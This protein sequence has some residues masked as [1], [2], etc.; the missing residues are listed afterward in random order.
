MRNL[1]A[2]VV[3]PGGK[4]TLLHYSTNDRLLDHEYIEVDAA[5]ANP[6]TQVDNTYDQSGRVR[7]IKASTQPDGTVL[8]HYRYG[9]DDTKTDSDVNDGARGALIEHV[10][11][12]TRSG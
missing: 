5:G 11:D 8:E 1:P 9:Y 6:K 3:D 10:R 4:R 7:I 12:Y 2:T